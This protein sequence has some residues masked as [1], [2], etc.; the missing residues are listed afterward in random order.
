[1]IYHTNIRSLAEYNTNFR[2]VVYTGENSQLVLMSI[3]PKKEIGSE[4][5]PETDQILFF[6][7][8]KGEAIINGDIRPI[9]EGDAVF[10]P[11]GTLHN[12]RNVD[13][14]DDLKLY[15]VYSPPKHPEGKVHLTKAEA[16]ADVY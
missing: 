8:G 1:M 14:D 15:T 4:V 12:F 9:E 11:A 16:D 2:Q 5:H 6:V 10:V 7:A 13:A 3:P